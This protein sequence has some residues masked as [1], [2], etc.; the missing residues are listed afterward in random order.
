MYDEASTYG[1]DSSSV[2][3][4]KIRSSILQAKTKINSEAWSASELYRPSGRRWSANL[5]PTFAGSGVW[6]GQR[7]GSPQPLISD[8]WTGAATFQSRIVLIILT[9]TSGLRSRTFGRAGNRNRD[10]WICSRELC[11]IDQKEVLAS[12]KLWNVRSCSAMDRAE[13]IYLHSSWTRQYKKF[14]VP[15][16]QRNTTEH[17]KLLISGLYLSSR[18]LNTRQQR[19]GNGMFFRPHV[20]GARYLLCCV[21]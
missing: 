3:E 13:V 10:L 6:R 11:S 1:L 2:D 19:F 12:L 21:P 18:I 15:A 5:V 17:S 7:E 20:R 14:T 4:T 16:S 9:R 8:F